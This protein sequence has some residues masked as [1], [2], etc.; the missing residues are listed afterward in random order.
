MEVYTYL[1]KYGIFLKKKNNIYRNRS[2]LLADSIF[3]KLKNITIYTTLLLLLSTQH[4]FFSTPSP[5]LCLMKE[6][7]YFQKR[8]KQIVYQKKKGKEKYGERCKYSCYCIL[9]WFYYQNCKR[10]CGIFQDSPNHVVCGTEGWNLLRHK[11]RHSKESPKNKIQ[12]SNLVCE[13][14][15]KIPSS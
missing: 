3:K 6:C 14:E 12:V 9:Q 13:W 8:M 15:Y 1:Q 7:L 2:V 10:R 5:I 11:C 4:Q